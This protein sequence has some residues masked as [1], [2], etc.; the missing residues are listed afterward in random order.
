MVVQKYE[1]LTELDKEQLNNM[2]K[3]KNEDVIS[4]FTDM[5]NIDTAEAEDIFTETQKFLYICQLKGVFIPNDL[6]IID[7]MW[8]N[9][10]LFTKEYQSYCNNHFGKYF[11]HLPA[12]KMEKSLQK[13][14]NETA[15]ELARNEYLKKLEHLISTAYDHLGEET[16]TKWFRHYPVKYS[17]ENIYALRKI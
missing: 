9:F 15:P 6:L 5:Y 12:S 10:I 17:K 4:R 1:L 7:E 13:Y 16:V 2:L 8:H 14:K 3:Y 11:H